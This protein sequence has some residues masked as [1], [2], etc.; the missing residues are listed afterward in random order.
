MKV[1]TMKIAAVSGKKIKRV[2]NILSVSSLAVGMGAKKL[3]R[4]RVMRAS[5][6]RFFGASLKEQPLC[7]PVYYYC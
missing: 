4:V 7:R 1:N 6:S 5:L 2:D 3:V